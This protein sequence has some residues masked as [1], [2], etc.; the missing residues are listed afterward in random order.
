[1]NTIQM[2]DAQA[3]SIRVEDIA[4]NDNNRIVL[5]RIKRNSANDKNIE[6]L[7][8]QNE[9]DEHGEECVDYVPE[10]AYDMGWLGYFVGKN[11]HLK[12]LCFRGFEPPSGASVAE[13][14][15]PFLMRMS[16]NNSITKLDILNM[17][18][19]GGKIFT[20]LV[21]FFDNN[22]A[23][24]N[25]IIHSCSGN[26]GWHLLALAIGSSKNK[27]LNKVTLEHNDIPDEALVDIITALSMHPHLEDVDFDGNQLQA[28]GCKALSTLLRCSCTKLQDLYLSNNEI[29]DEG[30]E[31]LVPALKNCNHLKSLCI[32]NNL[33]TSKGLQQ[34]ASILESPSSNLKSLYTN[35]NFIDD[36]ALS[37]FASSLVNNCTLTDLGVNANSITDEGSIKAFSKLL[38]DTTSINSTFQSNHTLSNLGRLGTSGASL[39]PFLDLNYRS[40]NKEVAMIKILQHHNDFDMMP[41]FEWEFKVLPLMIDWFERAS[42]IT[43]PDE[44]SSEESSNEESSNIGLRKLSNIGPRKLSSIY[45]YI[46]GMPLLYVE[47]RL[48]QELEDTK[49]AQI[50]IEEERARLDQQKQSNEERKRS[51][52]ERLGRNA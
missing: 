16:R 3:G 44:S 19:L 32:E 28:N 39:Q 26:E 18:L 33:I 1:M 29:N 46:R 45:Q 41:F 8:I 36:D 25:L 12:E 47:T 52:L 49:A 23:L 40:N 27:S 17:D 34:L 15:E 5:S 21:P 35:R 43:M 51:I 50:H 31:V 11:N 42:A 10:G 6:Y 14:L 9:H 30:I 2:Y 4:T 48:R 22:P 24:T 20:M 7:Y 13:V 37:A 38:C